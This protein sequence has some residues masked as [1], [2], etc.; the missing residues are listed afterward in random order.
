M[1]MIKKIRKLVGKKVPLRWMHKPCGHVGDMNLM[2]KARTCPG[3]GE[4][5]FVRD[6]K[7]VTEG[8]SGVSIRGE[9]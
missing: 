4:D 2:M 6:L 1:G 9:R 7:N 8:A 5:I 3:C